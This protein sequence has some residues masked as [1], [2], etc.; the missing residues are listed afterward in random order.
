VSLKERH[1]QALRA[2]RQEPLKAIN[3]PGIRADQD[4][5]SVPAAGMES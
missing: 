1:E 4:L 5:P 3:Q 2:D